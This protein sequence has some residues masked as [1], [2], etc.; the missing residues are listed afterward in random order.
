MLV[1]NNCSI[2]S[3]TTYIF[4]SNFLYIYP[5]RK[6]V[7]SVATSMAWESNCKDT[8]Q[9][10]DHRAKYILYY[11][12]L[13]HD[14]LIYRIHVLAKNF[15]HIWKNL[16]TFTICIKDLSSFCAVYLSPITPFFIAL[17]LYH[18]ISLTLSLSSF[19]LL[20]VCPSAVCLFALCVAD[21][22][23]GLRVVMVLPWSRSS[24]WFQ[25]WSMSHADTV[26]WIILLPLLTRSYSSFSCLILCKN[27][28]V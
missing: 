18:S 27:T 6:P 9:R 17:S 1:I 2:N 4:Q 13:H 8:Y 21:L 15:F 20:S 22:L 11:N 10:Y 14:Y 12:L 16:F 5:F 19:S 28:H 7:I 24:I 3:K 23:I 25:R 26:S